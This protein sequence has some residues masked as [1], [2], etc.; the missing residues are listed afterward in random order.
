MKKNE[1]KIK[2]DGVEYRKNDLENLSKTIMNKC[3]FTR[4]KYRSSDSQ[5]SKTGKG[6]L[7]FTNRLTVEEFEKKYYIHG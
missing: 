4:K 1:E 5:Y 2:I 6:K 7:M 3:K